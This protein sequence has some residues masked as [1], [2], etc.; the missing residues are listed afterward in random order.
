[1]ETNSK[2]K[3]NR[4][5]TG[6]LLCAGMSGR[7]GTTKALMTYNGLPFSVQII[8]K[9][10][11]VSKEVVVVLGHEAGKVKNEVIKH[12]SN[13]EI[14]KI[15]FVFNDI[16]RAGMFSSLQCGLIS[17]SQTDWILYHFVDQP[18]IPISF[19]NEFVKQLSKEVNWIQPSYKNILGHPILYNKKVAN[20]ILQLSENNSLRV[21]SNDQQIIKQIWDCN[22]PQVLED[23]D[24]IEQFNNLAIK[25]LDN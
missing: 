8:R 12:L 5:I 17:I 11:I 18:S 2:S 6:L 20:M 14:S 21:L 10:L 16:Y 3:I 23:I 13:D 25:Q 15:I 19:Y 1:M 24:T 22:Y 4:N 7:M 9:L